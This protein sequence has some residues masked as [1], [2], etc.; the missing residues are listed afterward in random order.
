MTDGVSTSK[1][2]SVRNEY[3][4]ASV[5]TATPEKLI[6]LLYDGA[7]Q[8]LARADR[9]LATGTPNDA[10]RSLGKAL[11]IV[12]ELRASLDWD[13]GGELAR[14]LFALYGF[15]TDR[16]IKANVSK[17]REPIAEARL[18]LSKLKEGWDAIVHAG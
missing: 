11:A 2:A 16:L 1:N 10:G 7:L 13:A 6:V 9:A 15:V 17:E 12:G 3:L 18:I 5:T 4:K 14:N 8:A